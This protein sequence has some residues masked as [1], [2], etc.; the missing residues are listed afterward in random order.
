[1]DGTT[2]SSYGI[3]GFAITGICSVAN[4]KRLELV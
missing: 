2:P 4:V 1:M 3:V